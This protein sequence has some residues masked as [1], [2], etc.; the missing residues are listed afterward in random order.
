MTLR[1]FRRHETKDFDLQQVQ[2]NVGNVL[3]AIPTDIPI[4]GGRIISNISVV[5]GTS[6]V[7][8][9]GLGRKLQ[10]WI[11]IKKS[12]NANIWDS[13][14]TNTLESRTLNLNSDA[15]VTIDLWVF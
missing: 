2:D 1:S 13:Q 11:A 6:K 8:N 3:N 10:G 15:N 7:I 4:A 9:H 12:A 14:L 5:S